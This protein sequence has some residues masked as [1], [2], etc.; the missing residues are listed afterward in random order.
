MPTDAQAQESALSA[1]SDEQPSERPRRRRNEGDDQAVQAE[2]QPGEEL[3]EEQDEG[4]GEADP[5][6]NA[7]RPDY[8][9]EDDGDG[10][11]QKITFHRRNRQPTVM[12]RPDQD[13]DDHLLWRLLDAQRKGARRKRELVTAINKARDVLMAVSGGVVALAHHRADQCRDQRGGPP[14]AARVVDQAAA[15]RTCRPRSRP[16]SFCRSTR[17]WPTS[18]ATR[19]VP[20][21]RPNREAAGCSGAGRCWLASSRTPSS[22]SRSRAMASRTAPTSSCAPPATTSSSPCGS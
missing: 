7:N 5:S 21:R 4:G 13:D 8:D 12:V 18:T 14:E 1:T 20:A 15:A 19:Y 6:M 9:I 22:A 2:V 16:T 3:G 17:W 10:A 11:I